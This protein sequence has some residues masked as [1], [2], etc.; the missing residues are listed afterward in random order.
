MISLDMA[1]KAQTTKAK[2]HKWG[3]MKPK[4]LFAAREAI[5]KMKRQP[6]E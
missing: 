6:T 1:A 2:I 3:Y 4:S 5:N